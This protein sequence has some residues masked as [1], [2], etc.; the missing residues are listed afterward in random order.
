MLHLQILR[1]DHNELVSLP[2]EIGCLSNLEQLTASSNK[3]KSL[4]DSICNL[5]K[6]KLLDIRNNNLLSLPLTI[7]QNRSLESLLLDEEREWSNPPKVVVAKG[8]QAILSYFRQG[9]VL[10]KIRKKKKQ[11]NFMII[12]YNCSK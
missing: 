2:A 1:I 7:Y 11:Q 8:T 12:S 4:P 9:E 5:S 6:L 3:L 10:I